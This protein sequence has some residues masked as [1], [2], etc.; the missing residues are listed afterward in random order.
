MNEITS[1]VKSSKM[2]VT[3]S[4]GSQRAHGQ[5]EVEPPRH[6]GES[7]AARADEAVTLLRAWRP[8]LPEGFRL[9]E[10]AQLD[11]TSLYEIAAEC[12]VLKSAEEIELRGRDCDWEGKPIFSP[13]SPGMAAQRSCAAAP[14]VPRAAAFRQW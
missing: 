14:P 13:F 2:G 6:G 9:P 4:L 11:R 7:L 12:R 1:Q 3:K 8:V 5:P 10:R